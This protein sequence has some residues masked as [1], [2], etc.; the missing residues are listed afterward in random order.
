MNQVAQ[1]PA[2]HYYLSKLLGYDTLFYVNLGEPTWSQCIS[3]RNLPTS[4]QLFLLTT[5]PFGFLRPV[6]LSFDNKSFSDLKALHK[7]V[8]WQI[9][10]TQH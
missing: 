5:P 4:S 7:E 9:F 6:S 8:E 1:T 3:N 2:Q 10:N